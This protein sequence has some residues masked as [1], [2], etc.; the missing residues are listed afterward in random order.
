MDSTMAVA[1][2]F[3]GTATYMS[4]ERAMG[5]NY[6]FRADVWAVGVVMYELASGKVIIFKKHNVFK[7]QQLSAIQFCFCKNKIK[8]PFPAISSF[9]ALFDCLCHQ[10]IPELQGDF[11]ADCVDFV[12]ACMMRDPAE[13]KPVMIYFQKIKCFQL[14][15]WTVTFRN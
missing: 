12:K 15:S 9:P 2:T 3:V 13:R 1:E 14:F 10:P 8:Y 5:Q 7:S 6:D 11:S 4:P